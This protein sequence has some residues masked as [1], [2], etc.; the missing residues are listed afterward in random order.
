M[1]QTRS[2]SARAGHWSA[3]HRK[4]A[5]WG[6][7]AFVVVCVVLGGSVG[8]EKIKDEDQGNGEA[9]TAARA[10]AT[11]G[12]KDR[13]T[14]RVLVQARGSLRAGDPQFRAAVGD[15]VRRADRD[16]NVT[17]LSSPYGE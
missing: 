15:V 2:L 1:K 9:R 16:P 11:A 6:W 5:I 17:N 7:I 12:L 8:T 13:A 4:T 3:T 14:E 10:V